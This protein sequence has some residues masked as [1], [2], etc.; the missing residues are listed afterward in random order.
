VTI[1]F[2]QQRLFYPLRAQS[3]QW[4]PLE[5]L[6]MNETDLGALIGKHAIK[7]GFI[8]C[9]PRDFTSSN[10]DNPKE[11]TFTYEMPENPVMP[12]SHFVHHIIKFVAIREEDSEKP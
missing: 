3:H 2:V 10:Q 12:L 5:D 8:S 7:C 11:L 4:S 9:G 1:Y 6:V